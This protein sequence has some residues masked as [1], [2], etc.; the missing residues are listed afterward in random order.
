MADPDRR[1]TAQEIEELIDLVRRDPGSPAFIDLGEAY[2]ALGRP[3]DAVQVGNLG[4]EAAPDS[5]EGRVMLA[6]AHA[7]LHQ[8]KE[9]Q[10]E[11]LR[12][13][14]IDR[15]NR[16]GFALLGEVLL[17]R[18]DYERAVPVLQ[19]A[20]NLDPTSPQILS[21]LKRARA[22]QALDAPP[23]VPSPIPPRGETDHPHAG[24][25]ERSRPA[26]P[27]IAAPPRRP[28]PAPVP[29]ASPQ[30]R[31][32]AIEPATE[33]ATATRTELATATRT[34]AAPPPSFADASPAGFQ[35]PSP[36][37]STA[38]T[39]KQT[40]PPPMSVEGIRPR[41]I[42]RDKEKNAAAASLRQSA[43][44]GET[45]LNDLL[46]GGLLDVAGVRAPDNDFDL[47]P[48][49][50]WG[51]STR[52]AF[53]FLFVVLV[54]GI[55]GGGT[56][57]W[58]SEKQKAEAVARLQKE[59]KQAIGNGDF[60]GLE[61]SIKKL[62]E[63]LEKDNANVLTFAY[64][65]ETAG[66]EALLYGTEA[67][68]VNKAYK[69]AKPEIEAGAAGWRELVI[70][71]AAVD[72]ATLGT[73]DGNAQA[74]AATSISTLSETVKNLDELLKTSPND[75]WAL[76]L[77]ARAELAGG[78]R[79]AAKAQMK[80]AGEG[81]DGL[82]VAMIEHADL[83]VDDGQLE[84][85]LAAY[86]KATAKSKDHPLAV[87]GRSL[88]RAEASVQVNEA[89]D[90]LSV[91]L[92]ANIGPRVGSYRN[93]ASALANIGIEDYPKAVESLRK[94]T[95]LKPPNEP[96]FWA[97][98]AWAHYT[99]GNL[100]ETAK[101]RARVVWFGKGKAEDDPTVQLVDA[102]LL[103]ASGLPEKALD[104]ASKIE[105]VRP[106]LLRVYALLD[107]GKAKE[108][109]GEAD[110]VLKM[111]P[112]NVEAA[113]LR[114]QAR[115][116]ATEG[117]DRLAA[118]DALEKL[119]RKAKSKL[120]RHAYGM[121]LIAT[122]D[123]KGAQAQLEQALA[124][125]NTPNNENSP[126]PLEYRTHTALAELLL[127][128]N[129]IAGAGKQL[130]E[131]LKVNSGYFPT[132]G[133]QA[134]IVLRNNEPDRAL[135]LL[136]PIFAESGAV[137]PQLKL[138]LAEALITHKGGTAKQ[139]DQAKA[140][141]LEVKDLIQPQTEVSR[142]AALLDPKLPKELGLPEPG[143][144]AVPGAPAPAEAPIKGPKPPKKR[145]RGR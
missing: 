54:L 116:I 73:G 87:V 24:A 124:D 26:P 21:M 79:K 115:M 2:L 82:V 13:V 107:L 23:P 10:G 134:R 67:D 3:R 37:S 111:A 66:L 125:I 139:K 61:T 70:G 108:A 62:S 50:R 129:D 53:I 103:L 45:Y 91:K 42:S 47:R 51:R 52:R 112:E 11:L 122:G 22:G 132:L 7:S 119:A 1:P 77:K 130:D 68:R 86:D 17:R 121:A 31:T 136:A 127:E 117:K 71:K 64:Y 131:A 28:A 114:E 109:M 126:N 141:I 29:T 95:A 97:R 9:A 33:P 44:V 75:K 118:T 38:R 123:P 55:G 74:V 4:L 35:M 16:Q 128:A 76:W 80:A 101:A 106:R 46:T 110:E 98:V 8:W 120:G 143:A 6:R 20:Q 104:Q 140:L 57:Y 137:T 88:G 93:L 40:A 145:G 39:P 84:E 100:A 30:M 59:A 89:I 144:A 56:W 99:S 34:E 142:V 94:A 15:S 96:R 85:A 48:D 58:W 19:H 102:A 113:I 81:D 78:E 72:L 135:D 18:S 92:S 133:L 83:M 138:T 32:M 14:K 12:V 65:T 36:S 60:A 27:P 41:V 49:R 90:E 69:S 25:V 63:S 43:A 105:G 5:L